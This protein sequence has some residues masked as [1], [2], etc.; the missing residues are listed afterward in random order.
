MTVVAPLLH[1]LCDDAAL[2]PPGNAPL[3]DALGAHRAHRLSVYADLVGSFV[4]PAARLAELATAG[5]LDV[6][7]T[8]AQGPAALPAALDR[9]AALP[10]IRLVALEIAPAADQDAAAFLA[11]LHRAAAPD[12]ELFVEVPRDGRRPDYL[13]ALAGAGLAAKFRTGGTTADAYPDEP[14]LA[15]A[16][17]AVVAAGVPAK[18]TAGLHHAV[19]NTGPVTGFEQ[20]GFLNVLLA[21]ARAQQ[22]ADAGVLAAVLADRDG[23]RLAAELSALDDDQVTRLRAA[24]RSF[25]TC[26]VTDPLTDLVALG[27]M[28][29]LPTESEEPA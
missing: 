20:H 29:A 17:T 9:L 4:L 11:A 28:P 1:R 18:A 19:R 16:L 27:L 14:E 2:F 6:S 5:P 3:P 10:D 23:G 26:S 7:V 13:R 22:G 24:F 15:A 25:G 8:L 21:V 12:V